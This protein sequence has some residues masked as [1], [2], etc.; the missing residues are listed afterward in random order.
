LVN[1]EALD[2]LT[3]ARAALIL[4]NPFFGSLALRLKLVERVGM[5]VNGGMQMTTMAV[6]GRHIFYHPEFVNSMSLAHVKFVVAHEVMHCVWSHM[7]RRQ[8]RHP[9]KWNM[10]GDYV[11]NDM[12]KT[13]KIKDNNTGKMELAFDMPPS[14]L[15]SAAFAG[16][17]WT[18][19]KVYAHLPDPPGGSDRGGKG[20]GNG[21]AFDH[22]L[23]GNPEG[24][25]QDASERAQSEREW[26]VATIQAANSA[27]MAGKLPAELE[28][29]LNDLYKPQVNWVERLR[30]FVSETTRNDYNWMR[31]NKRFTN[32][33]MPSLHDE[34][35]G[36]IAVVIDDSGSIGDKTLA[37]F[38]AEIRAIMQDVRPSL[39]HLIYCDAA[40]SA[41]YELEPDD[42]PKFECHGG[43][44][45]DFAPP[46]EKLAEMEVE[47]KC[48]IYLTDLM[49][50]HGPEP[51]YP[52]LWVCVTDTVAPWGE[53]LPIDDYDAEEK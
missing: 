37:V 25:P 38:G 14:G 16:G 35:V 5:V 46:F 4:D 15:W 10:A 51:S 41:H 17:D 22:V 21:G 43:G 42:I 40:V 26:K 20:D 52:V 23:D 47:P 32:L 3:K 1:K 11:I 7:S 6:D 24:E 8:H 27:K 9:V 13:L 34:T 53:T 28:R 29:F 30:N 18:A 50:P 2:K 12:L 48:L 49:G 31:P 44:G 33:Y 39:T 45:T 19:D 36:A